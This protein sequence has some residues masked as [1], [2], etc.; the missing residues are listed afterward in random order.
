MVAVWNRF[1]K[2]ISDLRIVLALLAIAYALS[3]LMHPGMPG[4]QPASPLGWWGW[5]DQGEYLKSANALAHY[6]LSP[7]KHFY[8]PLYP[9]LGSLFIHK[10]A[11][12]PFLLVNLA[13]FLFFA[14]VF[15]LL[16]SKYVTKPIAFGLFTMSVLLTGH[17]MENFVIPWTTTASAAL[18]SI[19]IYGLLRMTS[20]D[21][22]RSDDYR[23]PSM[24]A[25]F[26]ISLALGLITP[27]RPLD[28]LVGGIIWISFLWSI[29]RKANRAV[30][31]RTVRIGLF[32]A[33]FCGILIGPAIFLGFNRIVQGS[34]LGGYIQAAGA[35]G[36]YTADLAEKFV[37]IFIDG[38]T[39]YLE[40]HAGLLD[41]YPWLLL[42]LAGIIFVLVRGD[43]VLRTV[44]FAICAQFILYLPYGDLLPTGLWRYLNIHYFKWTF[45]YL[46]LFAW[47]IAAFLVREWGRNKKKTIVWIGVIATS[48]MLLLSLRVQVD[49]KTIASTTDSASGVRKTAELFSF[50]LS[51]DETDLIDVT[52][53]QGG[54]REKYFGEHKLWADG[55]ELF[56][57]RDFRVL[58]T[59]TG[60]RILFIRPLRATS[61]VFQ[62]DER[63]HRTGLEISALAGSYHFILGVPMPFWK[64]E[65]AFPSRRYVLGEV[66]DFTDNGNSTMYARAGWSG[67]ESWGRWTDGR[68]SIVRLRLDQ[69]LSKPL[70]LEMESAAFV[71][72]QHPVQRVEVYA[73]NIFLG[74]REF[75]LD[76]G[77]QNPSRM[78]FELPIHA[79]GDNG[80]IQLLLKIPDAV[81]PRKLKLSDDNR[82]L[83]LG[84]VSLRLAQAD[85]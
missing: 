80:E 64:S 13:S 57:Y 49:F 18:I 26:S 27:L 85:K 24:L 72:P 70:V 78:T 77:A 60:V 29:W 67:P 66:I 40:P 31:R 54:W 38:Y 44:A 53:L 71:R 25:S 37:S 17:I 81:S 6:D 68:K 9:L 41:H 4:N 52:G 15:L 7:A 59:P 8:P 22:E 2:A 47:L 35:N 34:I 39:L 12:N 33:C 14:A 75:N 69:H 56:K 61:I 83:G 42:S 58:P 45:P 11:H 10:M 21:G 23:P 46:A 79:V 55:R 51:A 73:N 28:S 16:A 20:H 62:P 1:L 5:Y 82:K 48:M 63:L 65:N 19:G 32:I 43:L 76:Q 3:Y 84:L 36:Y 50:Q 30:A 74:K